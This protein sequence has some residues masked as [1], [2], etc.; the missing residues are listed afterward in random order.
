MQF[1]NID[2]IKNYGFTGFK[3]IE[4]LRT[5]KSFIPK[6]K[7]VY[8]ILNLEEEINFLETGSG[9]FF[10]GKNP[11]VEI[12]TLKENWVEKTD[13]VYIGKAT[14]LQKRLNQYF[15]FGNGKN[16]GHYGGRYIWQLEKPENLLVCWKITNEDPDKVE[17]ELIEK[18]KE[19]YSKRPFANLVK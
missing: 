17:S 9:G 13:V 1:D 18:F 5:D 11:N 6:E 3:T 2:T 4:K 15:K 16:V 8:M 14:E 7:G 10:K 12:E 19:I